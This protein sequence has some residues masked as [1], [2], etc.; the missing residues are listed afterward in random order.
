MM[1]SYIIAVTTHYVYAFSA[2]LYAKRVKIQGIFYFGYPS[3]ISIASIN[4]KPI[5]RE[6]VVARPPSW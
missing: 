6:Y 3:R 5:S 4:T 1:L 2:I